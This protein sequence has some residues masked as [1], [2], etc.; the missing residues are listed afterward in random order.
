MPQHGHGQALLPVRNDDLGD[1]AVLAQPRVEV[2][3]RIGN[4]QRRAPGGVGGFVVV[5]GGPGHLTDR[6]HLGHEGL[7]LAVGAPV[8][9]GSQPL[10]PRHTQRPHYGPHRQ[11]EGGLAGEHQHGPGD[12]GT[13]PVAVGKQPPG[14]KVQPQQVDQAVPGRLEDRH[15]HGQQSRGGQEDHPPGH[16]D[17]THD[18]RAR[19]QIGGQG[20]HAKAPQHQD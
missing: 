19:D 12:Q 4:P 1:A 2:A 8:G 15:L 7:A 18:P 3:A 17:L 13:D 10:P 9:P 11:A 16:A 5:A 14:M 20:D 6:V